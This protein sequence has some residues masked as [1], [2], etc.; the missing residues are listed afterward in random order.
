MLRIGQ[1]QKQVTYKYLGVLIGEDLSFSEHVNRI[2]G[3]LISATFMLNQSKNSLPFRSRLQ[4]YRSIFESHLN[5]AAIAWPGNKKFIGRLSL[6]QNKVPKSVFLLP[7]QSHVT[8]LLSAHKIEQN[9]TSIGSNS[10][11][12]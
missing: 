5:F 7:Y 6:F 3:K 9:I 12:T 8:A 2:R 10:F 1:G 11:T 4:V